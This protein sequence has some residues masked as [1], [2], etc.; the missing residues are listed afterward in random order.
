MHLIPKKF[1]V[2]SGSSFSKVSSLNAFDV[3]LMEAGISEQNLVAV[4]SVIP[5]GAVRTEPENM[6]MGAVTHCV[7][8]Q[9]RGSGG[10]QIAAGI[11]YAFR[12]DGEGGYVA[13]GHLHGCRNAL[14]K[15]LEWKMREMARI[16]GVELGEVSYILEDGTVPDGEHGCCLAALVFTEYE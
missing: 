13:E 4:S 1:F 9:M 12:K 8:A 10:E 15:D 5:I 7:L 3:A 6:P 16:R 11:A 14:R 2:C